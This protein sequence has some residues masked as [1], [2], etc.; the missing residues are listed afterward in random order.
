MPG[1]GAVMNISVKGR[2]SAAMRLNRAISAAIAE[3]S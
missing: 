1:D 2:P 3:V